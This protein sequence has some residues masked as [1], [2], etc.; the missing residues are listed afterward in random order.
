MEEWIVTISFWKRIKIR[1]VIVLKSNL[2]K[3]TLISG[4]YKKKICQEI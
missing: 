4:E 2:M 1:L 3:K